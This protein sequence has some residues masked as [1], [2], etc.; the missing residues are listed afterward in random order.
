MGVTVPD[1]GRIALHERVVF[2]RDFTVNVPPE[3]RGIGVV[4]QDHR[5]FPHLT[6]RENLTF[7]TRW[8]T[9]E[10]S[11]PFDEMVSLLEIGALLDR[12]P[13]TLSGGEAQRVAL[14]RGVL[15]SETLLILDEPLASLDWALRQKLVASINEWGRALPFPMLYITHSRREARTLADT[16]LLCDPT[17]EAGLR[18]GDVKTL[19]TKTRTEAER[20]ED[21]DEEGDDD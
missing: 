14:A 9:R 21:V 17:L 15:A 10:G 13:A 3:E 2:D 11:V 4:Y 19:L 1:R 16:L 7:A 20:E 18:V 12:Y 6:V 8:G 5:L